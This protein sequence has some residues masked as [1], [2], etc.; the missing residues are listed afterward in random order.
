MELMS[1]CFP[2]GTHGIYQRHLRNS[3]RVEKSAW[4]LRG[5][6]PGEQ[7]AAAWQGSGVRASWLTFWEAQGSA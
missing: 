7:V 3:G 4:Y 2:I 6:W 5:C 1:V